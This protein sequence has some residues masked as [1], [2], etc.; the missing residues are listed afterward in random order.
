MR[1]HGF[2]RPN[3]LGRL[4]LQLAAIGAPAQIYYVLDLAGRV[5][6][7]VLRRAITTL[8]DDVPQLRTRVVRRWH[9]H[10]RVLVPRSAVD[11][12]AVVTVSADAG[13]AE[14]FLDHQ[15]DLAQDLPIRVWL[16]AGPDHDQL[17]VGL[18]HSLADGQAL[19]FVLAR[20]GECY[21]AA[22]SGE[23]AAAARA[24]TE[25]EDEARYRDLL[26]SLPWADRWRAFRLAL[27]YLWDAA[28]LPRS[29]EPV[30]V[31]T[32]TD[33]PLPARGRLRHVRIGIS[34]GQ[35]AELMHW[36]V[37]HNGS[38]TDVLLTA[39]IRA[40]LRVWPAQGARPI[41]VS[42]PV[43]VRSA[44]DTDVTN[45]VVA[46]DFPVD[47]GGFDAVF[48]QVARATAQAR[49]RRPAVVDMFKFALVSYLPPVIF[50]RLARRYFS[51]TTNVRESLT[52]T[53]LGAFEGGPQRFGSIAVTDSVFLGSVI[54]PPG[55]K[56]H[57][58]PHGGRLNLGVVYLDPV[59]T[60]ASIDAFS[61]AVRM[62]LRG[63]VTLR[64]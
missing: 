31:A 25:P 41:L 39:S 63:C 47:A 29:G 6:P 59:I 11:L 45:R 5:D 4:Y 12:E 46:M 42:L 35:A 40:A 2:A 13:S 61:E 14:A 50:N 44:A 24:S 21:E 18:H 3:L 57:V 10:R 34:G 58:S 22:L 32:F 8:L 64:A 26:G 27:G 48:A 33:Q 49:A 30:V 56:I 54:A 1:S 60:P 37:K 53:A 52:F 15:Q 28:P 51:R 38:L 16:H 9:G 7:A 62:E 43:S 17:V 20:L 55:L 19:V 23:P 36:A